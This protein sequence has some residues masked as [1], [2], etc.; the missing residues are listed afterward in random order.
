MMFDQYSFRQCHIPTCNFVIFFL[1][2]NSRYF[3]C[4]K[5]KKCIPI[6]YI[7]EDSEAKSKNFKKDILLQFFKILPI[8]NAK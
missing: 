5:Y 1:I 2:S 7:L 4:Q 6:N 3:Y 8:K